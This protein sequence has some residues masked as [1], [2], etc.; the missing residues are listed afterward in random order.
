MTYDSGIDLYW[1][2]RISWWART[3]HRISNRAQGKAQRTVTLEQ[4]ETLR[5]ISSFMFAIGL[6]MVLIGGMWIFQP[7][8]GN[9]DIETRKGKR[10][11]ILQN[12]R[13][14]RNSVGLHSGNHFRNGERLF[15]MSDIM[16]I[17]TYRALLMQMM[18][19]Y[20]DP[21]AD[22]DD[23]LTIQDLTEL[24]LASNQTL[25]IVILPE[26]YY[27]GNKYF[28]NRGMVKL[29]NCG[30]EWPCPLANDNTAPTAHANLT[31]PTAD[32]RPAE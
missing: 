6:L 4:A 20:L 24:V 30:A 10:Y 5:Q 32:V 29:C 31:A 23:E 3:V 28:T 15:V 21:S 8:R 19:G 2:I 14:S 7:D 13:N 17:E 9:G 27:R 18:Q 16:P 12:R 26:H 11:A 22:P 1:L 25:P